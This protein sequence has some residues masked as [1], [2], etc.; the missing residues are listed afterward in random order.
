MR[1]YYRFVRRFRI[2]SARLYFLPRRWTLS[3]YARADLSRVICTMICKTTR[4]E[5]L[6]HGDSVARKNARERTRRRRRTRVVHNVYVRT[7][8]DSWHWYLHEHFIY[9]H[10]TIIRVYTGCIK[11]NLTYGITFILFSILNFF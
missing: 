8:T 3:N 4:G 7:P 1:N 6:S 2:K 9:C 11:T 5:T 10:E